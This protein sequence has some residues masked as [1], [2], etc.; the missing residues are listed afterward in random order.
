MNESISFAELL[1]KS[2]KE[3]GNKIAAIY[4]DKS[5]TYNE[6]FFSATNIAKHI[7]QATQKSTAVLVYCKD[8]LLYLEAILAAILLGIPYIPI[9]PLTPKKRVITIL[10]ELNNHNLITVL[11]NDEYIVVTQSYQ[12]DI[13]ELPILKKDSNRLIY[14]MFTSGTTGVPK[15]I[16]ISEKNVINFFKYVNAELAMYLL[17][18]EYYI[19]NTS[20]AF[21]A[22]LLTIFW[23]L[24]SGATLIFPED[25][26]NPIE[27]INYIRNYNISTFDASPSF[28]SIVIAQKDF[29]KC[30]SLRLWTGGGE[31]WKNTLLN[32]LY[33]I[34]PR[35]K[36]INLYGPTELTSNITSWYC[37]NLGNLPKDI[38]IGK[39]ICNNQVWIVDDQLNPIQDKEIGELLF[40]GDSVSPGYIKQYANSGFILFDEKHSYLTGDVGYKSGGLLYYVGRKDSQV[41]IRGYRIQLEEIE[42]YLQKIFPLSQIS[43]QKFDIDNSEKLVA[44]IFSKQLSEKFDIID[45]NNKLADNLPSYMIPYEYC[46]LNKICVNAQSKIDKEY[47]YNYYI[48]T[49]KNQRQCNKDLYIGTWERILRKP[50][51]SNTNFFTNGGDSLLAMNLVMELEK[52]F[53]INLSIVDIFKYPTPRQLLSVIKER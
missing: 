47:L 30:D 50:V 6:L 27:I 43:V 44:F 3:H 14:I 16:K 32:Q 25:N 5:I 35:C 31:P 52:I 12:H 26:R 28:T 18:E 53:N 11:L 21:D 29:R 4:R 39:P 51:K 23:P 38:P 1:K 37:E 17:P 13:I 24:L 15:G 42:G 7:K 49:K 19:Q 45:I 8:K 36:F 41:K 10:K 48:N 46:F 33:S 2:D 9:D 22:S 20:F 34:H 40:S